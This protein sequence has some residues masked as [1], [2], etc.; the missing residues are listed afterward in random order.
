MGEYAIRKSDNERVKIGTCED[1][2]YLRFE[3]RFDVIPVQG[4]VDPARDAGQLRFRLPFPDEDEIEPGD[5]QEFE[6][7]WRLHRENTEFTDEQT[8]DDPGLIQLSHQCG[9]LVNV[10]CYHGNKLPEMGEGNA[11]WNGKS[12]SLELSQLRPA[13]ING[14]LRVFPVVWCRHCRKAWRYQWRD[15]LDYIAEPMRSRLAV[16][17]PEPAQVA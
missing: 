17:I 10:P 12:W 5:F 1:M 3:Q 6:R 13:L 7:G 15:V 14:V 11:L 8:V 16:Y 2:Y 4:S 9:L